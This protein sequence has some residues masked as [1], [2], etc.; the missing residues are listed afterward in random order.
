MTRIPPRFS[1]A[2]FES[3]E[4]HT[5]SQ[6]AAL[7][8]V[9]EWIKR[10][11]QGAM[12]ALIGKQGTGKSHLLYSAVRQID[13]QFAAMDAK[14]RAGRAQP[15]VGSWYALADELRFGRTETTES[16]GR[17]VEPQEVRA[18]LW[19]RKVVM[20]DEVRATSGTNFDDNE[21]AKFACHAYDNRI[22][23]LVTTNVHPLD[24][25]F[26]DAA[27]SRFNQIVIDGPDARQEA[28]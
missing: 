18:R 5:I 10:I 13:A 15:F 17:H 27:A 1:D 22:A 28:A 6:S 14:A 19:E 24:R 23:V 4:T 26:G 8:A 16:G 11:E 9:L 12:L 21:L 7:G 25:V 20:L 3:Y 2:S